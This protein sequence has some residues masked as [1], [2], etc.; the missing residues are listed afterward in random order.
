MV[1]K[2]FYVLVHKDFWLTLY[3]D[4]CQAITAKKQK[5]LPYIELQ[6]L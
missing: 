2:V 6:T 1:P 3:E 5:P 4:F